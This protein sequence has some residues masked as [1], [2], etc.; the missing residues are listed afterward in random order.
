[1]L[2]WNVL[3]FAPHCSVSLSK[4]RTEEAVVPVP[5]KSRWALGEWRG[6]SRSWGS[7]TA[8]VCRAHSHGEVLEGFGQLCQ[9]LSTA[10][11][12]RALF[13]SDSWEHWWNCRMG[14]SMTR[15]CPAGHI[16]LKGKYHHSGW[17][18]S[19]ATNHFWHFLLDS[20]PKLLTLWL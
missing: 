2:S 12:E 6:W 1:M 7:S 19:E 11:M 4:V 8:I 9:K 5:C 10:R 18:N 14:V 17:S 16:A 20:F 3:T 15:G 13:T